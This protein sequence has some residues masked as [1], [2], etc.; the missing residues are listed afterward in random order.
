MEKNV[1]IAGAGL[2]G[3]TAAITLARQ[4]VSVRVLEAREKIGHGYSLADSSYL[5]PEAVESY[6]GVDI[7]PAL[8][9]WPYTRIYAYGL[10]REVAHPRGAKAYTIERGQGE[11]SLENVLYRQALASGVT[12]EL[13]SRLAPSELRDLPPGSIIATGLSTEAFQTLQ[14][15]HKPF[16]CHLAMGA[17]EPSRPPVIV[18][19]DSFCREFGYYFQSQN[20]AGALCFNVDRPL[21]ASE[22]SAFKE[23]LLQ[24]DGIRFDSWSDHLAQVASWPLGAG[25]TRRLFWQDKILCGT[26]AGAISPVLVFGVHGALS[27]GKIAA[28]AVHDKEKAERLFKQMSPWHYYY[29]QLGLRK[30]RERWPHAI[31]RPLLQGMVATYHPDLFPYMMRFAMQ[32]PGM[33]FSGR[34]RRL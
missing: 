22:L 23:K 16:Y 27:S 12:V 8:S 10:R 14:L 32:P 2:A 21:S 17:P 33:S 24:N 15:P 1:I 19:F 29:P 7:R 34:M 9:P 6:L 4:G 30:M 28:V 25:D 20:A 5:D 13:K 26:I 31:L 3:L 11:N 18:Y